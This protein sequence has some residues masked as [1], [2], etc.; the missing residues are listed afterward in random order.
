[1]MAKLIYS[2]YNLT[3]TSIFYSNAKKNSAMDYII[4]REFYL[5]SA[6][7]IFGIIALITV[8]IFGSEKIVLSSFLIIGVINTM[9]LSKLR[10]EI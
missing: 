4:F 6:K 9:W 3:F 8:I 1:M 7:L 10:E 5:H 2:T